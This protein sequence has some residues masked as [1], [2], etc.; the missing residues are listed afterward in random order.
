LGGRRI[1]DGAG[2]ID[3]IELSVESASNGRFHVRADPS[4]KPTS[5]TPTDGAPFIL[6][7]YSER[8]RVSRVFSNFVDIPLVFTKL[9]EHDRYAVC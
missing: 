8:H 4:I 2:H 6:P 5:Y 3:I 1:V 9:G 7:S